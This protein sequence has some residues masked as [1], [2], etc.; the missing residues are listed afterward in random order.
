LK[1]IIW[2]HATLGAVA[3]IPWNP[4]RQKNR[5]C[6]PPTW[7]KE[8]LGKRTGIERFGWLVCFSSFVSNALI[9]VAGLS[10]G[11]GFRVMKYP[12]NTVKGIEITLDLIS[13]MS[14]C[15]KESS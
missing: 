2:I 4:K 14:Y 6:L 5:S 15:N 13:L 1:L 12:L 11:K 3:V 9:C 8:E 10:L 7:T